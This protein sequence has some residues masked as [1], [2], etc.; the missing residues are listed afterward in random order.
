[1]AREQ[2]AGW[3]IRGRPTALHRRAAATPP[4]SRTGPNAGFRG[5][6]FGGTMAEVLRAVQNGGTPSING[7]DNLRTMALSRRPG[8]RSRSPSRAHARRLELLCC[9]RRRLGPGTAVM[10]GSGPGSEDPALEVA[11][12]E[13]ADTN[14]A[15]GSCL[16]PGAA[17]VDL[18][19]SRASPNRRSVAVAPA[20]RPRPRRHRLDEHDALRLR[21]HRGLITRTAGERH[22]SRGW[23]YEEVL[24]LFKASEGVPR[25]VPFPR[26]R[27][28]AQGSSAG[29]G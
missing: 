5:R 2:S 17:E 7:R 19:P 6:V 8:A 13:A 22:F 9:D 29:P 14:P 23:S 27:R 28:P 12:V 10:L 25:R 21:R 3:T 24:P 20:A 16:S 11:H 1:M 18:R 26:H 15:I 4:S